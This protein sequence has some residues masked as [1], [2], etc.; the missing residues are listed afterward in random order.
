MYH[1][2]GS[3]GDEDMF[4]CDLSVP[5]LHLPGAGE[6]GG[7]G[8]PGRARDEFHIVLLKVV[9]VDTVQSLEVGI[10]LNTSQKGEK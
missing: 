8:E 3:R 7:A 2:L 1:R 6:L 4:G 5:Y 9:E 10:P